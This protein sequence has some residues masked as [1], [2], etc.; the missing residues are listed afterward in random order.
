MADVTQDP[1][2]LIEEEREIASVLCD[3]LG[4]YGL[5]PIEVTSDQIAT[6]VDEIKNGERFVKGQLVQIRSY[7]DANQYGALHAIVS[8]VLRTTASN[9]TYTFTALSGDLNYELFSVD[10]IDTKVKDVIKPDPDNL[11]ILDAIKLGKLDRDSIKKMKDDL[12]IPHIFVLNLNSFKF[13]SKF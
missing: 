3:Q 12:G 10:F 2:V 7:K 6:M 13:D 9:V 11:E 4:E 5:K 1:C 8:K